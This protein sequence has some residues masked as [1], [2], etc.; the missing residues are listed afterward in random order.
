[1]PE[2][3]QN[4]RVVAACTPAGAAGE[5]QDRDQHHAGEGQDPPERGAEGCVV[6]TGKGN[7]SWRALPHPIM[8]RQA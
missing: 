4:E 5:E 1:M 7:I 8:A 6:E 2:R 3:H